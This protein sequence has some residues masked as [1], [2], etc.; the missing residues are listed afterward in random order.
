MGRQLDHMKKRL[1]NLLRQ[2]P[3]LKDSIPKII[4]L[5]VYIKT[6]KPLYNKLSTKFKKAVTKG[7]NNI[8]EEICIQHIAQYIY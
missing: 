4:S 5:I 8:L 2:H 3:I 7:K 1:V 6:L